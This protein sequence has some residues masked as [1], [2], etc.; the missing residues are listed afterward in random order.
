M[1]GSPTVPSR[2]GRRIRRRLADPEPQPLPGS[3][4]LGERREA[5]A[6]D[7]QRVGQVRREQS[8]IAEPFAHALAGRPVEIHPQPGGA[9]GSSPWASSAPMAPASTSPV[10]PLASAGFSNGATATCPSGAA[11]TV[12]APLRTTT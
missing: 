3:T 1:A 2:R 9:N 5:L 7:R 6:G 12:R 4:P 8:G 10:P 11:M